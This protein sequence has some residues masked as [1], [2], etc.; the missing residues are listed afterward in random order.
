MYETCW[1]GFTKQMVAKAVLIG[2]EEAVAFKEV[3]Y[4]RVNYVLEDLTQNTG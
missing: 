3:N 4:V 1:L 2:E